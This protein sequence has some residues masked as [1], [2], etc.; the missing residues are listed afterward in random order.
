M[1]YVKTSRMQP[2]RPIMS[3]ERECNGRRC[4]CLGRPGVAAA[5]LEQ[6]EGYY[7][8]EADWWTITGVIPPLRLSASARSALRR[9]LSSSSSASGTKGTGSGG[10]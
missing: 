2:M 6:G 9:F 7:R 10:S 8:E 1:L 5:D 3:L 4:Q